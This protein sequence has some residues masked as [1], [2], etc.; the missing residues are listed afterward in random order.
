MY[1]FVIRIA[2]DVNKA[3]LE[4]ITIPALRLSTDSVEEVFVEADP[5]N[6][7]E[8]FN[9]IFLFWKDFHFFFHY[10]LSISSDFNTFSL[11]CLS[12]L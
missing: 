1:S 8:I 7:S 4:D 3:V 11:S 6:L 12:A 10:F 9:N 5:I 2:K